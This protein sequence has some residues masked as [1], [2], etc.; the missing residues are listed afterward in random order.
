MH[1]SNSSTGTSHTPLVC[2]AATRTEIRSQS[3]YNLQ[4]HFPTPS[5][6]KCPKEHQ[7]PAVWSEAK[8]LKC[9]AWGIV[10]LSFSRVKM[11]RYKLLPAELDISSANFSA[12]LVIFWLWKAHVWGLTSLV[13]PKKKSHSGKNLLRFSSVCPGLGFQNHGPNPSH[14]QPQERP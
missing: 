8:S 5:S 1:Q 7:D 11:S 2:V 9:F 12:G 6:F 4:V 3:A 10:F 14:Y 13:L